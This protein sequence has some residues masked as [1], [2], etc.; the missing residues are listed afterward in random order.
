MVFWISSGS[1]VMSPFSFL[2]SLIWM[3]SLC[4]L[5]SLAKGFIY[6]VDVLQ[7][8]GPLVIGSLNSSCF[9][10]VDFALEFDYFLLSTPLG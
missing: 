9:H 1:V 10:V 6:L 3:L 7:E 4:P 8:P 2:I 5:A